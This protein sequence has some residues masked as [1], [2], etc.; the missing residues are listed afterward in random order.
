M[1]RIIIIACLLTA[2][3]TTPQPAIRAE[4]R[5]VPMT[6][7]AKCLATCLPTE[8]PQWTC[9]HLPQGAD[10]PACWDELPPVAGELRGIGERCD[11]ARAACV[12][13][14]KRPEAAGVICGVTEPCR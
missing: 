11:I 10:D 13:C 8:W 6:C 5:A 12:A 1:I 7:E 9:D 4:T 14:L 3:A 2:C